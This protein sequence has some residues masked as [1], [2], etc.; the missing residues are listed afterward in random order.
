MT[1]YHPLSYH[2]PGA[3]P[4][5]YATALYNPADT[6]AVPNTW[7]TIPAV[8]AAII[9]LLAPLRQTSQE[10]ALLVAGGPDTTGISSGGPQV[11]TSRGAARSLKALTKC[12][13]VRLFGSLGLSR[14][15]LAERSIRLPQRRRNTDRSTGADARP[16]T[17]NYP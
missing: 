12:M 5:L 3:L 2:S 15:L 13:P 10:H 9:Y 16:Q 8:S 14:D 1:P 7:Y 6:Y 4:T 11:F 17:A